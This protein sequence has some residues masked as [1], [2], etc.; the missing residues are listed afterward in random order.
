MIDIKKYKLDSKG[1]ALPGTIT[2]WGA[3]IGDISNQS[4]LVSYINEHGG[5]VAAWGS[6]SGNLS[7][8]TDLMNKF[9]S[10]ATQSWISSQQFA[11]E[12]WVSSQGYL[13]SDDL[14]Q[15]ATRQWVVGRSYATESWV[16]SQGYLTSIPSE[17][18]TQS[19]VSS[20]FCT[21]SLL[22]LAVRDLQESINGLS[23]NIGVLS[24]S[25]SSL[26]E[27]VSSIGYDPNDPFATENFVFS[28]FDDI[29]SVMVQYDPD[30][31][32][33]EQFDIDVI[34]REL[35][36][37]TYGE[38]EPYVLGQLVWDDGG[39]ETIQIR[40]QELNRV[41]Y[42]LDPETG[43]LVEAFRESAVYV[44]D[45]WGVVWNW[46]NPELS[47]DDPLKVRGFVDDN[48]IVGRYNEG[49]F[50]GFGVVDLD[51]SGTVQ[52]GIYTRDEVE[53]G[54]L[55]TYEEHIDPFATE[56]YVTSA[57]NSAIGVAMSITN[58]ILS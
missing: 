12:S 56:S 57:I 16:S 33:K 24:E 40:G 22:S 2:T 8:Q 11:T 6:I 29:T 43:D 39:I 7:D 13:V 47:D 36:N 53:E 17:Y 48:F 45:E 15:Y 49:H 21:T 34:K 23:S 41:R 51:D 42:E 26:F 19:W 9:S 44:D 46:Y 52:I 3:I 18:A 32:L 25:V 30:N 10:Y 4:D 14:S 38:T 20:N 1:I 58:E 28:V 35:D 55:L 37:G 31:I 5:G 54:S 50:E 27:A